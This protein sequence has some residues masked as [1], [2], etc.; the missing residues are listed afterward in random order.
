MYQATNMAILLIPIYGCFGLFTKIIG[1]HNVWEIWAYQVWFGLFVSPWYAYTYAFLAET[2]PTGMENQIF[3]TYPPPLTLLAVGQL[4]LTR[5][6]SSIW[7][8]DGYRYAR[9]RVTTVDRSNE[10]L[11]YEI[12]TCY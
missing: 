11:T 1:F 7:P 4:Q 5:S 8:I 9:A 3:G 12:E 6:Q 10:R 2:C